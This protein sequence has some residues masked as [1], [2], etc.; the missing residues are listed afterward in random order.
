MARETWPAILMITSSPAPASVEFRDQR[1]A[2]IATRRAPLYTPP[3][4]SRPKQ[5][6]QIILYPAP[7]IPTPS[8][9]GVQGIPIPPGS[10]HRGQEDTQ[11][12]YFRGAPL[13]LDVFPGMSG[14]GRGLEE[15][16]T[17]LRIRRS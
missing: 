3:L 9:T 8:Q 17:R 15:R 11:F 4:P 10:G 5:R 16:E 14:A 6:Q 1:V 2:V 12:W 13:A 7:I